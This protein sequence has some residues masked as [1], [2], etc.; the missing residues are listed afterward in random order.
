M[1]LT[2]PGRDLE[3]GRIWRI[4]YKGA[5]AEHTPAPQ[6][7]DFTKATDEELVKALGHP[8][9]AVRTRATNVLASR[10]EG[11]VKRVKHA[12]GNPEEPLAWI[13][14]MWVL[15]RLGALEE[16]DLKAAALADDP[17]VRVHAMRVLAERPELEGETRR[18]AVSALSEADALVRRCAAGALGQHPQPDN[19]RPLLDAR[20][21]ADPADTHLVH[22]IRMALRDT[23]EEGSA[24]PMLGEFTSEA[25]RKALA[26]AAAGVPSVDAVK[27]L[28]GYLPT[29]QK[30]Q[31]DVVRYAHWIARHGN[32]GTDATLMGEARKLAGGNRAQADLI[33]GIFRGLQERGAG[34]PDSLNSWA[35]DVSA[36]LIRSA[37]VDDSRAGIDLARGL[38]LET[39][40]EPLT[41][42]VQNGSTVEARRLPAI[43]ALAEIQADRAVEPLVAVLV[44]PA[45]SAAVRDRC[46]QSLAKLNRDDARKRLVEALPL[47]PARLQGVIAAALA[48]SK[49]GAEALLSTVEQGKASARLLQDRAVRTWLEQSHVDKLNERL[50]TLTSG[51]APVDEAMQAL[52]NR[53]REQFSKSNTSTNVEK[54]RQVFSKVCA[55][56]HQL[57]GEGARI[58]PQL[59]GVGVRGPDRLMEDLLDPN[60]NVDQAFR[61]T[62]LALDDGR[63]LSGL[64]LND[65]GEVF[66]LADSQGQEIRVPKD[67]VDEQKISPLSPMPANLVDQIEEPA[68]YDL[69]A[70]LLTQKEGRPIGEAKEE[71]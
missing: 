35:R 14:G 42:M 4:V 16:T 58:G 68:F 31:R 63:I 47:A 46:A 50:E 52:L 43:E 65:E 12:V 62:T 28:L 2:H 19:L 45:A 64:L 1:P 21:A 10:G 61:M 41:E 7:G 38:R 6:A 51:L 3:R 67:S 17:R 57:G 33:R 49:P 26:D 59:D 24:W 54:G 8:N 15:H 60:R 30:D 34:R 56:C 22:V 32:E 37:N 69:I 70:Y 44:D 20:H 9:L 48:Q 13:H 71:K 36:G 29:A 40:V 27:Y 11:V 53:R 55:A 5:N 66:T 18:L 23:L 39:A 25:D